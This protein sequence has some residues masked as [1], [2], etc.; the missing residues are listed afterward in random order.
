MQCEVQVP[1]LSRSDTK[2]SFHSIWGGESGG[3]NE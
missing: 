2:N 3:V 1:G